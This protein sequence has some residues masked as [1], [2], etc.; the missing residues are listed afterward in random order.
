M[1]SFVP[2]LGMYTNIPSDV[3]WMSAFDD[4]MYL[5]LDSTIDWTFQSRFDSRLDNQFSCAFQTQTPFPDVQCVQSTVY[6]AI[7]GESSTFINLPLGF[8]DA[9][10]ISSSLKL[11]YSSPLASFMLFYNDMLVFYQ[12]HVLTD[13]SNELKLVTESFSVPSNLSIP[14]CAR[15]G[16]D[17]MSIATK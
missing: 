4:V 9:P 10:N 12:D 3:F 11:V 5:P 8:L 2:S 14:C 15:N 17:E 1:K 6:L 7:L 16:H 13:S